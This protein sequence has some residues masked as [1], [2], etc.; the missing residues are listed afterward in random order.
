[1][2]I[3]IYFYLKDV[4]SRVIQ[5]FCQGSKINQKQVNPLVNFAYKPKNYSCQ[6]GNTKNL[7]LKNVHID[8]L[9]KPN[10]SFL[11]MIPIRNVT[12]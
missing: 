11:F 8:S 1:M 4:P 10:D 9:M 2:A 12:S 5:S 3:K 6:Q 7:V